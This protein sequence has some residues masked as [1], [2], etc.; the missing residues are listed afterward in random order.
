MANCR[1]RSRKAALRLRG[2]ARAAWQTQQ[3]QDS[4]V[5]PAR[6]SF[7]DYIS[8]RKSSADACMPE[9]IAEYGGGA[10]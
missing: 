2:I 6:L 8:L 4:Q 5:V 9:R 1:T 3:F 10:T 7:G